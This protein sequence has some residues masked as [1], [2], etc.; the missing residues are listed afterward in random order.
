MSNKMEAIGRPLRNLFGD[1]N[2]EKKEQVNSDEDILAIS[3][4]GAVL[5]NKTRNKWKKGGFCY[6]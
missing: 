1:M 5:V 4:K 3:E 6:D 2:C